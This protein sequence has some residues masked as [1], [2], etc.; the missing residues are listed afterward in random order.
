MASNIS[1]TPEQLRGESRNVVSKATEARS[2]FQALRGRLQGL[3]SMFTGA[4]QDRFQERYTEWDGHAKGLVDALEGLGKFL[5]TAA[6][7][8]EETDQQ[9]AQGLS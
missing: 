3:S 4:A 1:V 2:E 5:E 9:L 7:T 6:N 8:L